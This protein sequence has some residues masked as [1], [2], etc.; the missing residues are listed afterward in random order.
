ME[1]IIFLFAQVSYVA[2]V[3]LDLFLASIT[4]LYTTKILHNLYHV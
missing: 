2:H 1:F 4:L 3:P